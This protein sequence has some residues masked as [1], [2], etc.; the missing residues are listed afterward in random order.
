MAVTTKVGH[1][2]VALLPHPLP[3][4]EAVRVASHDL[5]HVGGSAS[6]VHAMGGLGCQLHDSC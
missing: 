4:P 6:L 5:A 1:Q 2:V 3:K